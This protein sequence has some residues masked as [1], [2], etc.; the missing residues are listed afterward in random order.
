M[1]FEY[2]VNLFGNA[3]LTVV[4]ENKEDAERIL[5]DTM[6]SINLKNL[7]EKVSSRDDVSI[8]DSEVMIKMNEK[9]KNKDKGER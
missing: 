4:A 5:K 2:N 7:K 3:A 8:L 9:N 6:E 1:M